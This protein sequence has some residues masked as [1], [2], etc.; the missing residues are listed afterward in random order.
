MKQELFNFLETKKIDE[1]KE[2]S[3]L[4]QEIKEYFDE[5][6]KKYPS[7]NLEKLCTLSDI[8][9]F[10]TILIAN[11]P[12]KIEK[13]L[14]VLT[15]YPELFPNGHYDALFSF[16]I[17][18]FNSEYL[19]EVVNNCMSIN[20]FKAVKGTAEL[21][22][23][24]EERKNLLK[25]DK[26]FAF[27]NKH[28]SYY[29]DL[30]DIFSDF[31][32]DYHNIG[33]S[34]L[35]ARLNY[36]HSGM[37]DESRRIYESMPRDVKRMNKSEVLQFNKPERDYFIEAI[38]NYF[39][40]I[41]R[42]VNEFTS[43]YDKSEKARKKHNKN[44]DE[45][46]RV[47]NN[48][49]EIKDIG[50]ILKLCPNDKIKNAVLDFINKHN[51][52]IYLELLKEYEKTKQNTDENLSILFAKYNF[53]YDSYSLKDKEII[54]E[55]NF[56]EIETL[57]SR[58]NN[59][60]ITNINILNVVPYKLEIVEELL[61]KGILNK[62]WI[63]DNISILYS[64]NE[65]LRKI[66]SNIDILSKEGINMIQYQNS[67][68]I[69]KSSL[70][71]EN[72]NI[73]SLYGLSI[74]KN[75]TNINFLGLS[76]LREKIELVYSLNLG[77]INLDILNEEIEEILKI[78]IADS[79]NIPVACISNDDELL[80]DFASSIIPKDIAEKLNMDSNNMVPLPSFFDNYKINDNIL[81]INGVYVS[82]IKIKRNLAK[83]EQNDETSL[84][85]AIIYNGYYTYEEIEILRCSLIPEKN[86]F[87]GS[88]N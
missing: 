38:N 7:K 16:V 34:F 25:S 64:D 69:V 40:L 21:N 26:I 80:C 78:K 86:I 77:L 8:E 68:D 1:D 3:E 54:K 73:L 57:L 44:I 39:G 60:S 47:L 51:K 31:D 19:F 72:L 75:T 45:L 50:S 9:L 65:E 37:D 10:A 5:F 85:Y 81:C 48:P 15:D 33:I 67:L 53:N 6:Y 29:D 58:L 56:K 71:E 83:L 74:T 76:N 61:T 63:N 43:E 20:F 82:I 70:I 35:D 88:R 49:N 46:K 42:K 59:L 14:E 52:E 4:I 36:M 12:M 24:L 13:V 66:V 41:S 62:A 84:F 79:L 22:K 18:Y 2:K 23:F 27:F 28:S 55:M 17:E 32:P 87:N 11:N 30:E